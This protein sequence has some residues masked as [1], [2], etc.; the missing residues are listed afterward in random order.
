MKIVITAGSPLTGTALEV[1]EPPKCFGAGC[2]PGIE[3][4]AVLE[5]SI[6][7]AETGTH[8]SYGA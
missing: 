2:V 3:N 5:K 4:H 8:G 1:P 6:L 7:H